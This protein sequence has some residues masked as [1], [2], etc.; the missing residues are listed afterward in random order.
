[1]SLADL[2]AAYG[3][4][5]NEP[6]EGARRKVLESCWADDGVYCDPTATAEGRDGLVAHIAGFRAAL[7]GHR[8]DM[9]TAVDEHD[10]Y[11][12]FGWEMVGPDGSV[13]LVG[14]DFGTL[15]DDGRLGRIVGFFGPLAAAQEGVP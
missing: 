15:S 11:L 8:I 1:M 4:A 5:W 9:T 3:A 12:R 13:V 6:E 10:G 14:V 2:V 7:P